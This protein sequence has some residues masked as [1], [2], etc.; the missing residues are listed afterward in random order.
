M[1]CC[2]LTQ[3]TTD[4]GDRPY[5]CGLCKDTFS[6]SDILK[7]HFQKCSQRRGNPTGQSH[8]SHSR[9]NKKI[10]T[11]EEES[12]AA[13][14]NSMTPEQIAQMTASYPPSTLD[15]SI[16]M[17]ALDFDQ[18]N[19]A[20]RP[21]SIARH[22]SRSNSMKRKK[23]S[24]RTPHSARGSLGSAYESSAY[25]TGHVTPDS[26][27]TSGA[28]TPYTTYQHEPRSNQLSPEAHFNHSFG[29]NGVSRGPTS[30][31]YQVNSLPHIVGHLNGRGQETDWNNYP[32]Y[33]SHDDFNNVQH[34]SGTSTPQQI[35]NEPD[36]QT[37]WPWTP[38]LN[39]KP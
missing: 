16:G 14:I 28:A 30:S 20:E 23:L 11:S 29:L 33:T 35:K 4:T 13:G 8:L 25:S 10:K 9:A 37:D 1:I 36:G 15:S 6:R 34:P 2:G 27:T 12:I 7:R 17:H 22:M 24:I 39:G 32:L 26:I 5:T 38:Y 21:P 19:Y 3:C 18:P 31:H